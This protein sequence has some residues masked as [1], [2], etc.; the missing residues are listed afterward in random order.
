MKM[1][2]IFKLT[3]AAAI[4]AF[5]FTSCENATEIEAQDEILDENVFTTVD[6]LERGVYGLYISIPGSSPIEFTSRFVDDLRIGSGNRGQGI[7]VFTWS[8]NNGTDEPETI[9]QGFYGAINVAN[10]LLAGA[11]GVEANNDEE[12]ALKDRIIAE[13]YA[14]RAYAHFELFR[15]YSETYESDALSIPIIDYIHVYDM[16]SRNTVSEVLDFV[17]SDL[18]A[19]AS[20]LD[21]TYDT[22]TRFSGIAVKALQARVALYAED[23]ESA[24]DYSTEVIDNSALTQGIDQYRA[25]WDDTDETEVLFELSRTSGQGTIG[26]LFTDTNGDIFFS[27]SYELYDVL[28]AND[29][30]DDARTYAIIDTNNFDSSNE[31]NMVG[32]YLGTD[33]NY[34]LNNIKIFRTAEQYLIRAEAYAR[35]NQLDLAADDMEALKTAR[36]ENITISVNYNDS[37]TALEDILLERRLELA[38]EGHRYFDLVRFGEISEVGVQRYAEDCANAAGACSLD[39]DDYRFSLPIPQSEI[40]ANDN[41][42]QNPGY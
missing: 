42:A 12:Q 29:F 4:C 27:V 22:N 32:K 26:T 8:I 38:F 36:K 25:M 40:F 6:D 1:K 34:G 15:F 5:T 41:M 37:D 16:P 24:I 35:T 20:V 9:W 3:I 2:N 19:A 10:R 13:C 28:G 17:N 14:V 21:M 30:A 23:Y 33:A 18:E 7:Q 39:E 31:N 11:E